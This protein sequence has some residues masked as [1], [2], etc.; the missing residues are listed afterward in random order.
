MMPSIDEEDDRRAV[1]MAS[2]QEAD[3]SANTTSISRP[4]A[5]AADDRF[6][7]NAAE[8]GKKGVPLDIVDNDSAKSGVLNLKSLAIFEGPQNGTVSVKKGLVLY[9][10]DLGFEGTDTL[11]YTIADTAGQVS[12]P[13]SVR[14]EV[15]QPPPPEAAADRFTLNAAEIGKKGAVLDILDNDTPATG[16]FNLKSLTLVDGPTNGTVAVK[17]GQLF[18][19][20]DAGF[21]GTETL[22]Y[23]IADQSGRASNVAEVRIEVQGAPGS[24]PS[25]GYPPLNGSPPSPPAFNVSAPTAVTLDDVFDPSESIVSGRP[26]GN[27][28]V[29]TPAT[30]DVAALVIATDDPAALG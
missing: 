11:Q 12:D 30:S 2:Q 15:R 19:R 8:V 21:E 18:Y 26:S 17:K 27:S 14:I 1:A 23:T 22:S 4:M 20:P 5:V 9:R 28:F 6:A 29:A 10:P 7:I 3:L 13:A 25:I 16:A 24:G